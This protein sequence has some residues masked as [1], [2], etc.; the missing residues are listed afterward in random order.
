MRQTAGLARPARR[1]RRGWSFAA[2]LGL[3][4]WAPE[5]ILGLGWSPFW[6]ILLADIGIWGV[7]ALAFNLLMGYTGLVSF[8]QAAYLG[9]GG[10]TAGLLLKKISGCPFVLALLAAPVAGAL[11]AG[12]IGACCVRLTHTY[13][14]MLTLAFSMILYTLVSRWY[15]FTGGDNGL[16]GIP[17]PSWVQEPTFANYYKFVLLL[18]LLSVYLLWR[19]VNAPLGKTLLAVRDNPQRAAALGIPVQRYQLYAFMVAGAFS[20]LAGALFMVHERSVYPE[21][22]FW[23]RSTQVLLMSLL[24]GVYTFLGPLLGACMLQLM[25]ADITS[26]YPHIWQLFLGCLL[27]FMLYGLPGGV[28]GFMRL[29]ALSSTEDAPTRL[30]Q[31]LGEFRRKSWG[32]FLATLLVSAFFRLLQAPADWLLSAV[33]TA[34]QAGLGG[35]LW[36]RLLRRLATRQPVWRWLCLLL[37][38]LLL[39][40]HSALQTPVSG[41]ILPVLWAVYVAHALWQPEISAAWGVQGQTVQQPAA[42]G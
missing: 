14:A 11:S 27:V 29:Q 2:A 9:I 6:I 37:P 40:L 24:G 1:E 19:L 16:I 13:F 17:V 35:V 33:L 3:G 42:G 22:A 32:F 23:T 4:F 31:A 15:A 25:D 7:F 30:Q 21:L 28:L 34:A 38:L 10:Y 12:L 18:T 36:A 39:G 20:G 26:E 5:L 8:G 41:L